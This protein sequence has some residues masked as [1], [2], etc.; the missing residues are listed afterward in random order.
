MELSFL[1][2][3]ELFPYVLKSQELNHSWKKVAK[4]QS[5]YCYKKINKVNSVL[6]VID[7]WLFW[8]PTYKYK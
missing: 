8:L 3:A 5:F 2:N 7:Q 6:L 4:M 1:L